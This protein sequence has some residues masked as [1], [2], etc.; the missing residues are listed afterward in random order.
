VKRQWINAMAATAMGLPALAALIAGGAGPAA[1][2]R[3]AASVP[4]RHQA[5]AG[6][7]QRHASVAQPGYRP[8]AGRQRV[9]G[10]LLRVGG[11]APG[12]PV[13]LTGTVSAVDAAGGRFTATAG[14]G[15][16]FRLAL[17]PGTYR[18]AGHSPLIDSG[19]G[20]CTAPRPLHVTGG[21]PVPHVRVYC[22]I[23]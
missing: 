13:P 1:G 20:A 8:P 9:T 4:A 11:P 3:A 22:Q 5:G 10:T 23:R 15:G 7:R 16:T 2:H 21:E 6:P 14:R 17:P 18:L 12:T 19:A